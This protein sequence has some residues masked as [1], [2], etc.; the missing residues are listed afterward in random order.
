MHS[1]KVSEYRTEIKFDKEPSAVEQNNYLT[2]I[3]NVYIVYDLDA[4]PRNPTNNFKFNNCLFGA[5]SVVKY[6]YKEKYVYS[7]YGM[8]FDSSRWWS[9]D[10]DTARNVISFGV[11]NSSSS[12]SDKHKNNF[13]I[14][15]EGPTFAIYG[16][17][18]SPEK[19]VSINSTKANTKFCLGLHYKV[20]NSFLFVNGREIFKFQADNKNVNFSTRFCLGSISDGFSA[21]ESREVSLGGNVYDFSV[22]YHSIDKSDMLNVEKHL[23]TKNN[24][25]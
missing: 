15:D 25:K 13:L 4:W 7:G 19:K 2:K 3:V 9:F 22:G 8:T 16:S 17:F 5:N 10:S 20:E 21:T 11:D 1:I 12:H 14:L 6:S 23:M 24:I 18:G